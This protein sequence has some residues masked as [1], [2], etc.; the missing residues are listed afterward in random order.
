MPA[1]VRRQL[2]LADLPASFLLGSGAKHFHSL[3]VS[4][5]PP[6]T[7][8]THSDGDERN[9]LIRGLE[10]SKH[11]HAQQS[12]CP[13]HSHWMAWVSIE[14]QRRKRTGPACINNATVWWWA[15][16]TFWGVPCFS[17][18]CHSILRCIWLQLILQDRNSVWI[19]HCLQLSWQWLAKNFSLIVRSRK[20]FE[21]DTQF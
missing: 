3:R 11:H 8:S 9:F 5:A 18:K 7:W 6:L 20:S 17:F 21:L 15:N 4:S 10:N 16:C 14:M 19:F 13:C 2:D 12:R 1:R